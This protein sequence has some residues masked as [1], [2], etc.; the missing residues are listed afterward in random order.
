V[1]A[2]QHGARSPSGGRSEERS[3]LVLDIVYIAGVIGVFVLLG[4]LGKAV[5]GL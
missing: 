4:L 2:S 1:I 3:S 5:E